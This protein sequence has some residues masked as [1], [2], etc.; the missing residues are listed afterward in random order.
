M[1]LDLVRLRTGA[2]GSYI[3]V[4]TVAERA[5]A[6]AREVDAVVYAADEVRR[7]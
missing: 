4:T 1:R 5:M 3:Q 6:L 2:G 7:I